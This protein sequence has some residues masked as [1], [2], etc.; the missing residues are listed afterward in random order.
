MNKNNGK[1]NEDFEKKFW[2]SVTEIMLWPFKMLLKVADYETNKKEQMVNK[3][4][5]NNFDKF[6]FDLC[7]RFKCEYCGSEID[8]KLPTCPYCGSSYKENEEYQQRKIEKNKEY[9]EYL[10][11]QEIELEKEMDNIRKMQWKANNNIIMSKSF[12]NLDVDKK[13]TTFIPQ[14]N[15]IFNCEFCGTKL[16]GNTKDGKTCYNCG[17][18]YD[19]NVDLLILEERQEL[20]RKNFEMYKEIQQ[21]KI[22]QNKRNEEKDKKWLE[23]GRQ[24]RKHEKTIVYILAAIM[25]LSLPALFLLAII[26]D[27]ILGFFMK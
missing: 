27:W 6:E 26:L 25:F 15:F 11:Q 5:Q 21:A 10:K 13:N 17:A 7:V 23:Y 16:E 3:I 20:E 24:M 22:E 9:L 4:N 8:S 19:N 1:R 2:K 12:W 18:R 14:E